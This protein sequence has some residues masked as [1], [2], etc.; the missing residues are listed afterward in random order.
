M[1]ELCPIANVQHI[2]IQSSAEGPLGCFRAMAIEDNDAV[3]VVAQR[4]L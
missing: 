4:S 1:A 2:I 3:N